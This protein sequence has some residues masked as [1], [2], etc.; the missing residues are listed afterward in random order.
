[1]RGGPS[2]LVIVLAAC[3]NISD[4]GTGVIALEV[5]Q[6]VPP[7]VEVGDTIALSARALDREGNP[8]DVPIEWRTPDPANIFVEAGTGRIAG[9]TPGTSARVQATQGSLV[10]DLISLTVVARADTLEV[11]PDTLTVDPLSTTSPALAPRVATLV[12][13]A[14]VG[15]PG[16]AVIYEIVEPAFADPAARTVEITGTGALADTVSS[17]PDGLP[18]APVSL[19]RVTGLTAPDTVEVAV[20]VLRRSGALVPGSGQRFVVAFQ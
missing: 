2:V 4:D 15:L 17:G 14:Y 13:G 7:F 8:V 18:Q 9:I 16:R 5:Q 1:M 10:S 11:P 19:S 6:P 3:A 12:E 20:R